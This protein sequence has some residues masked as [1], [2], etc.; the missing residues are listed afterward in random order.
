ML[1]SLEN[2]LT[3]KRDVTGDVGLPS[4]F[5]FGKCVSVRVEVCICYKHRRA[6]LPSSFKIQRFY[7]VSTFLTAKY[8]IG[9]WPS[10][11]HRQQAVL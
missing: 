11:L 5:C 9:K 7:K 6:V 4:Q 8:K 3:G 1:P 2:A 10:D